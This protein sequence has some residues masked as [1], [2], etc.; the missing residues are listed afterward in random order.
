M[1]NKNQKNL[2]PR[3]ERYELKFTIPMD[4]IQPVSDFASVYCSPDKYSLN[5]PDGFYRVNNLYFDSPNYHF[6]YQRLYGSDNRFNMRVRSYGDTPAMPY[7]LE[8]KQKKGGIIRKYR[9]PVFDSNW[10]KVFTEPG[11][12]SKEYINNDSKTKNRNLFQRLLYTYNASPKVLTQYIRKAWVSDVDDY[13]RVTFDIDL[14]YMHETNY[15]LVPDDEIMASCDLENAFDPGCSVILELK[16]Y[17][18]YVPLWMIDLIRYFDLQRRSFSKYMTG[19]LEVAGINRY[20]Q[21]IR[22]PIYFKPN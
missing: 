20:Y 15:N 3:L 8:I 11:F 10:Y 13:A 19:L 12:E 21:N 2:P 7:F 18:Q 22:I 17:T 4:L 16:C 1:R 9:S 14:R 5:T 6:L